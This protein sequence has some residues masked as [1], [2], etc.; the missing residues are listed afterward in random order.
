VIKKENPEKDLVVFTLL[1]SHKI[2]QDLTHPGSY[3]FMRSPQSLQFY[4]APISVMEANVE[5]NWIKVSIEVKGIKTKGIDRVKEG[6]SMLIRAPFW[7]GVL[8]LRN[9]FSVKDGTSIVVAR[10]IGLAPMI[11]VLRKLYS[12]GNR[13][14]TIIDK[15]NYEEIFVKNYLNAYDCR[16][17]ECPTLDKGELSEE[18]K[19][20]LQKLI[21]TENLNLV[22]CDGPDILI[23][24]MME[25]LKSRVKF[26]CCNNAKMCCGEGVCGTCS[27]RYK[28]HVVKRLCKV[29]SDPKNLFEGRRLI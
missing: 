8:G 9:L 17:I 12:N 2:T 27:V 24:K 1:T 18:I 15:A 3:I 13:L 11:P 19:E 5:E 29:Q 26:S 22:H 25:F 4:D 28:G 10:G 14:I 7:N 20:I 6:E 23:F 16:I 21:D